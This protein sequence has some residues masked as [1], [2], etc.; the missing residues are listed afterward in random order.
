M[1]RS[2]WVRMSFGAKVA[3]LVVFWAL[4]PATAVATHK[5]DKDRTYKTTP[6]AFLLNANEGLSVIG[7]ALESRG[8]AHAKADC[9]HLVNAVYNR[10]GF[11]YSYVSSS[12][13]YAGIE[14][15][16][17]VQRIQPGD[18]VVWPGHVGIVINPTQKTFFSALS[19]GAGVESYASPYWKARGTPRFYRYVKARATRDREEKPTTTPALQRAALAAK[20]DITTMSP[21]DASLADTGPTEILPPRVQLIDSQRPKPDQVTQALLL[22][23]DADADSLR[24]SDVFKLTRPLIVVSKLETKTVKIHG[25]EGKAAVRITA[26]LS[27][28][29]DNVNL[30][31]QQQTQTWTLR[32]R[33]RKSWEVSFPPNAIY[34]RRDVAV[35]ALSHQLAALAD[36]EDSAANLHQKSQ[37]AL[38][39]N[40]LLEEQQ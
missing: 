15:F 10:A 5:A 27:V 38:M 12:D 21:T 29:A 11:P 19:A 3:P 18:L 6:Q 36:A 9:S 35:R 1:S 34:V 24:N 7:A 8:R 16:H 2:E 37:L 28:S 39:L 4:V 17:R 25:G 20:D 14:E 26:A 30:V 33:D 40:A 32:R 23:I 13:L 31:K 22:A